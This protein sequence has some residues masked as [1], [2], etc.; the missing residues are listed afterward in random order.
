[1]HSGTNATIA[2]A[3]LMPL[4]Q[5]LARTLDKFRDGSMTENANKRRETLKAIGANAGR[6]SV[7]IPLH[8]FYVV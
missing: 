8:V 6:P 7:L 4:A 1:M 3:T 5:P 2:I